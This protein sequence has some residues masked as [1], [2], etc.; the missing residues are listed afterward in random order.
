[1]RVKHHFWTNNYSS[2]NGSWLC[3]RINRNETPKIAS[4]LTKERERMNRSMFCLSSTIENVTFPLFKSTTVI[5]VKSCS[6]LVRQRVY[7]IVDL[8]SWEE[9]QC[10]KTRLYSSLLFLSLVLLYYLLIV[11]TSKNIPEERI[12]TEM[13]PYTHKIHIPFLP[14][15]I[16]VLLCDG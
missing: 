9:H 11:D 6:I 5:I 4:I 7:Q 14:I 1:M 2:R 10:R 16:W 13:S 12:V 15:M 8:Y 3:K